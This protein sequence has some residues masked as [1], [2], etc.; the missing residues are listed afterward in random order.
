M[1][2]LIVYCSSHGTTA[3][4]AGILAERLDGFVEMVDLSKQKDPDL[5]YYDAV[6]VG[7]SIHAGNIQRKVKQFINKNH[8]QLINKKLGFFLCC[9]REGDE[10]RAQ[11]ENA[12]PADL[13]AIAKSE[14]LFGGEFI[15][16]DMNL[17]E[18]IIVKKVAGVARDH[19]TFNVESINRFAD[20]FN[21]AS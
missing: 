7:G 11:F 1:N 14:G 5:T 13:R 9:Y 2:S 12:F 17:I 8:N 15:F 3:R 19:S 10:A 21:H 4:A 18:R 6:I 16:A 20:Q